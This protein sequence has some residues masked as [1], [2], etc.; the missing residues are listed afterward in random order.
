MNLF[1]KLFV[2]Q[3]QQAVKVAAL[4]AAADAPSTASAA[5]IYLV[6]LQ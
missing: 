6:P 5:R 3:S 4:P 1:L 2:L